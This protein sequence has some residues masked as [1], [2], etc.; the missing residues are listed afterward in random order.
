V[1]FVGVGQCVFLVGG[2][3]DSIRDGDGNS[4]RDGD[5]GSVA[6]HS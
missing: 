2:Y 6:G 4:I 5:S 1:F 3:G